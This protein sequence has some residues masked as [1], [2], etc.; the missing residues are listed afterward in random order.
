MKEIDK[1]VGE[2]TPADEKSP[3]KPLTGRIGQA[4]LEVYSERHTPARLIS[5]LGEIG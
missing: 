1:P 2:T 4:W 5:W 3:A